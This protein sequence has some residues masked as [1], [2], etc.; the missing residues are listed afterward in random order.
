LQIFARGEQAWVVWPA[1]EGV[2]ALLPFEVPSIEL[3]RWPMESPVLA[4]PSVAAQ[5]ERL[6][7]RR[8]GLQSQADRWLAAARGS[9]DLAQLEWAN[10]H[11]HRNW[12]RVGVWV[13]GLWRAPRWRV[14]RWAALVVV[15]VN[16]AGLNAWAWA[17]RGSLKA[18]QGQVA[19][20]LQQSFPEVKVVIDA[21]VQMRKGLKLRRQNSGQSGVGDV[22]TLLTAAAGVGQAQPTAIE[23]VDGELRL[24]GWLLTDAERFSAQL[25]LAAQGVDMRQEGGVVV[26]RGKEGP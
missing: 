26:L 12:R 20:I 13:Q 3:M 17:Q 22:E 25:R 14:A 6:L 9:W 23:Y 16:L 10:A 1:Q 5:A 24:S 15:V 11:A 4:E 7:Q 19:S 2:L 18:K 21:P 8:V